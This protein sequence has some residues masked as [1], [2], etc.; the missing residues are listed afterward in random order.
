MCDASEDFSRE[1]V[2]KWTIPHDFSRLDV[3]HVHYPET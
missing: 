2:L 3:A 1:I